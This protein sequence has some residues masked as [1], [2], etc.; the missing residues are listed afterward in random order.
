MHP[1]LPMKELNAIKNHNKVDTIIK[2][3]YIKFNRFH[4][5]RGG[6]NIPHLKVE[7]RDLLKMLNSSLA[8]LHNH[9]KEGSSR[10][11]LRILLPLFLSSSAII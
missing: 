7:L 10:Q 2:L 11:R 9:S 1:Y 4:M 8:D 3:I 5:Y 6:F